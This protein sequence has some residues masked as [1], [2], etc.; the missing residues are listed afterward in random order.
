MKE[1][2]K[3][4]LVL[5]FKRSDLSQSKFC[6]KHGVAQSS[7]IG[8]RKKYESEES[9]S[10]FIELSSEESVELEF[11]SNVKVKL[12]LSFDESLLSKL[13]SALC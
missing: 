5:E 9:R 12:P 10:S 8:W 11:P 3:R 7:F 4:K 1:S 13:M 2:S 6:K